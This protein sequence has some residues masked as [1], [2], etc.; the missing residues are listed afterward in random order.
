MV[1]TLK[2]KEYH[3]PEWLGKIDLI[4]LFKQNGWLCAYA[5]TVVE[6][7]KKQKVQVRLG[8]NDSVKM[9]LNGKQVWTHNLGRVVA[10]DD[11]VVEVTLPKGKS[12][13]L[14]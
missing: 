6:S 5:A 3:N 12:Q 8:S 2:W 1:K 14:Y 7:P 10:L 9:W 4:G 13:I 11:D